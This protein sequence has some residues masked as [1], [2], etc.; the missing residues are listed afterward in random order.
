MA[1]PV[2]FF[3][4]GCRQFAVYLSYWR[5]ASSRW[6]WARCWGRRWQHNRRPEGGDDNDRLALQEHQHQHHHH[7]HSQ[8]QQHHQGRHRHGQ[9]GHR[10]RGARRGSTSSHRQPRPTSRRVRATQAVNVSL[11]LAKIA[12][13][14]GLLGVMWHMA[15]HAPLT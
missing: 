15:F 13:R 3:V 10:H 11:Y 5:R 1:L 12:L 7:H 2:V 9:H 8:Q 6:G 4:F 14:L